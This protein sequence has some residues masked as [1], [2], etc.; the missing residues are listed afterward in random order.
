MSIKG[1]KLYTGV[2]TDD[3]MTIGEEDGIRTISM[4]LVSGA[5]TFKGGLPLGPT[6]SVAID[7]V[8]GVPVTVGT[9]KVA[10]LDDFKIDCSGGGVINL[11]GRQ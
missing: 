7:L 5:G 8:V 3:V 2:L 4:V 1:Q 6:P 9:N 10:P 11:I